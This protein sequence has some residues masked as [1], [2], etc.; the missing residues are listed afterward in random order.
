[1]AVEKALMLNPDLPEAYLARG[2]L[3]WTHSNRFPHDQAIRSYKRALSLNPNFDEAHHQLGLVYLHVGLLDEAW[4][5][6]EKSL[7][8]NPGNTMSRFRFG[9]IQL[10]R[11]RYDEALTFFN[12][13]PLEKNPSLWAFQKASILFQLGRTQEAAEVVEQYLR[14]YSTDEGGTV[15]SVKALLLA[16]AGKELE[17][18]EAIQHTIEIGQGFGHF[19]HS[20]YNIASSYALLNKPDQAIKWLRTAAD[21]GLP[22]YPLFESDVNLNNLRHTPEFIQFM[23]EMRSLNDR[24]RNEV[25]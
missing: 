25:E 12:T 8:I 3:L 17:A 18:E 5:E 24:Y 20:A 14:T 6:I 7:A 13:T 4:K 23:A 22:C 15:T 11:G 10:Y 1:M 21:D 9:V 19:H 2:L 16:K